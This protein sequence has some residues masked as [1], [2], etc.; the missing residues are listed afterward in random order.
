VAG[1]VDTDGL[2]A[3]NWFGS[4]CAMESSILGVFGFSVCGDAFIVAPK[5]FGEGVGD[6]FDVLVEEF[7]GVGVG[8]GDFEVG[9]GE[10]ACNPLLLSVCVSCDV[11]HDLSSCGCGPVLTYHVLLTC[12][13]FVD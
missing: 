12:C 11:E 3:T 1:L 2:G 5:V 7:F 13:L 8:E 6:F 4:T 10:A 9:D